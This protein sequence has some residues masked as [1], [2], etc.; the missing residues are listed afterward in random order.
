[1]HFALPTMQNKRKHTTPQTEHEYDD[2]DS[3]EEDCD[4]EDRTVE[5]GTLHDLVHE[6]AQRDTDSTDADSDQDGEDEDDTT[7]LG[8]LNSL[9]QSTDASAR[10]DEDKTDDVE[11]ELEETTCEETVNA[12]K[13]EKEDEEDHEEDHTVE[14][15]SLQDLFSQQLQN[16]T[17]A[18]ESSDNSDADEEEEHTVEL[19][20]LQNLIHAG[21]DPPSVNTVSPTNSP[22][23]C[24]S[25][26]EEEHTVAL[27]D[28]QSLIQANTGTP[29]VSG[30]SPTNSP[31]IFTSAITE[32]PSSP[33]NSVIASPKL[34]VKASPLSTPADCNK[35][36]V[37]LTVGDT[38]EKTN[39]LSSP[40]YAEPE[41]IEPSPSSHTADIAQLL[42]HFHFTEPAG[43]DQEHACMTL[44][45]LQEWT[46][47]T[48][49]EISAT[50]DNI[51]E[52]EGIIKGEEE[53]D[54]LV[55]DTTFDPEGVQALM[56]DMWRQSLMEAQ[57]EWCAWEASLQVGTVTIG[58]LEN[59]CAP[60]TVA[61]KPHIC[62]CTHHR[63][64]VGCAITRPSVLSSSSR[65]VW[66][67]ACAT[68]RR[69][70]TT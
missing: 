66:S 26:E 36:E 52:I 12:A 58:M 50:N 38:P 56:Q 8:A 70:I 46:G 16:I 63:Q 27:G 2:S 34:T 69:C 13:V 49:E 19:G 18:D 60:K 51:T 41:H 44:D 43:W 35:N 57:A 15:G 65:A 25:E 32:E 54:K 1:M 20:N 22:S 23:S 68:Q 59:T 47:T 11:M 48:E 4:A 39:E 30:G 6:S 21:A 9:Y 53:G 40:V 31:S 64:G 42:E 37:L 67:S 24:T 29:S 61:S 28:L 10:S 45:T 55:M 3:L 33:K 14:V 17:D 62:L 5:L 7:E